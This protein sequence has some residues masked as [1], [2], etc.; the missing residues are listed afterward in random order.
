[1][2]IRGG[3][4]AHSTRQASAAR[5]GA[6]RIAPPPA[7]KKRQWQAPRINWRLLGRF[8][9]SLLAVAGLGAAFQAWQVMQGG[10]VPSHRM[11]AESKWASVCLPEP[12]GPEMR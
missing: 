9:F 6:S 2:A 10:S 5:R 8:V 11:A 3:N 12:S 7:P 1:M 4:Q